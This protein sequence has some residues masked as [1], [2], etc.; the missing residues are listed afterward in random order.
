MVLRCIACLSSAESSPRADWTA[1]VQALLLDASNSSFEMHEAL[2]FSLQRCTKLHPQ[3][4]T[5]AL[6]L[7]QLSQHILSHNILPHLRSIEDSSC[8]NPLHAADTNC[9]ILSL[10]LQFVAGQCEQQLDANGN[11]TNITGVSQLLPSYAEAL[12]K[13]AERVTD[14]RVKTNALHLLSVSLRVALMQSL[15]NPPASPR[16]EL[17]QH[18]ARWI[19]ILQCFSKDEQPVVL[20]HGCV[21]AL[22]STSVLSLLRNNEVESKLADLDD[23]ATADAA[24]PQSLRSQLAHLWLSV[25]IPLLQDDSDTVREAASALISP[26]VGTVEPAASSALPQSSFLAAVSTPALTLVPDVTLPAGSAVHPLLP[27][28]VLQLSYRFLAQHFWQEAVVCPA[29][30]SALHRLTFDFESAFDNAA[31]TKGL[32]RGIGGS[33]STSLASTTPPQSS[34]S[35]S[36]LGVAGAD[37]QLLEHEKANTAEETLLSMELVALTLR[38][39]RRRRLTAASELSAASTHDEDVASILSRWHANE[40]RCAAAL[41]SANES[42]ARWW[43]GG[44]RFIEA[45]FIRQAG[46]RLGVRAAELGK[47]Q[48][49]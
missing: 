17:L 35:S 20:R 16:R 11:D 37:R 21:Q 46:C 25:I 34:E 24:M 23:D 13:F 32:M 5:T 48:C 19:R 10:S 47:N 45:T 7:A 26:L 40:E 36:A 3:R 15:Q 2:L 44:A 18:V 8:T 1:L 41:R 39:I 31:S 12:A 42:I 9:T 14:E 4:M 6:D 29:L 30:E 49:L 28:L 33:A 27:S 38:D 43:L 22:A